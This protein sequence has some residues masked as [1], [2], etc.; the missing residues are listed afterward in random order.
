VATRYEKLGVNF[1]AMVQLAALRL[2][3]REIESTT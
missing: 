3:L 2:W 1:L